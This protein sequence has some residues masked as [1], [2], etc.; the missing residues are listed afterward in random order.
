MSKVKTEVEVIDKD[1]IYVEG[2]QYVSLQRMSEIKRGQMEEMDMLS[3]KV[4]ELT[5][6]NTAYKILLKDK[7]FKED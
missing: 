2:K 1:H 3:T 6:E 4:D 7:L 5:Q